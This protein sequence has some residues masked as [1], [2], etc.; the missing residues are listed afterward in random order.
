MYLINSGLWKSPKLISK[1]LD[2]FLKITIAN[3]TWWQTSLMH[4]INIGSD[5]NNHMRAG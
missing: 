2:N 4:I 5:K 3:W 1:N